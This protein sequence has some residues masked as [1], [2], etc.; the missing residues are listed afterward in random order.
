[1]K[2]SNI[3]FA[4]IAFIGLGFLSS[5]DMNDKFY[6]ELDKETGFQLIENLDYTLTDDDYDS[7]GEEYGEPGKYDNFSSSIAPTDYLPVFLDEMYPTLDVPSTVKV[8]YDFHQGGLDYIRDYE[9]LNYFQ[10][11]DADYESMGTESGEPGNHHN[12]AY[13]VD[14]NDFLPDFLPTIYEDV[15]KG[16]TVELNYKYYSNYITS[17][18]TAYWAFDGSAWANAAYAT[19]EMTDEDYESMGTGKDEPGEHNNFAYDVLPADWLPGF[20]SGKYPD[21]PVNALVNVT[22]KYYANYETSTISEY[23]AFDGST[24]AVYIADIEVPSSINRYDLVV[25]DYNAMG[26]DEMFEEE[27]DTDLISVFLEQ[28]MPYAVDGDV[29]TVTYKYLDDDVITRGATEYTKVE[30]AWVAYQSTIAKTDQYVKSTTGWVYDPSVLYTMVDSDYQLIVDYVKS[31]I[32]EEYVDSY[33]T[34]DSYYGTSAYYKEFNI[35]DGD[36]DASFATWEDAVKE[37]VGVFLTLRFPD[38][39]AQVDGVDVNYVVTFAGYAGSMV[40]YT[41]TFKCTKSGPSPEFEYVE[42]PTEK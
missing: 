14:P 29:Y 25:D 13:N 42:G 7:M 4:V 10:F 40:D 28:N 11:T 17:I 30:G 22:Y 15:E 38:A 5:C 6:D 23:W 41:I 19:H 20:L 36:F 24:W 9:K 33:G 34:A 39:A 12:F 35:R 18:V 37:A 16:F 8:T 1:M 3:L 26:F 31:D 2:I 32:G 21:A 27:D